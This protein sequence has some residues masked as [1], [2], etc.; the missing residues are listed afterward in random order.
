MIR[1]VVHSI[2]DA[3]PEGVLRLLDEAPPACGLVEI[4]AD[5]LRAGDVSGLVRRA[6]RPGSAARRR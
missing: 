1:E 4:R 5:D 6:G 2:R 3:T